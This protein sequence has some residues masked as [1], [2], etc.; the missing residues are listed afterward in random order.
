MLS[1]AQDLNPSVHIHHHHPQITVL[2]LFVIQVRR[3]FIHD[4]TKENNPSTSHF[5]V[6]LFEF[7]L[8]VPFKR[9]Y[10][11]FVLYLIQ[12]LCYPA[13]RSV[14]DDIEFLTTNL[15]P[16]LILLKIRNGTCASL[17]KFADDGTRKYLS[18]W[19]KL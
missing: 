18:L 7:D 2:T 16:K 11:N 14:Y 9:N 3:F 5:H 1:P 4:L 17:L 15:G 12:I 6:S 19:P 13:W 8:V 10:I